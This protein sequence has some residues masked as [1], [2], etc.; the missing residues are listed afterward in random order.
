[1][2]SNENNSG[3][4]KTNIREILARRKADGLMEE[5]PLVVVLKIG[6]AIKNRGLTQ[7]DLAEMT[8]IRP[9]AISQMCRGFVDRLTLDHLQRIA[10]ALKI[11]DIRELI[12]LELLGEAWEDDHKNR[13]NN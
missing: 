12:D 11:T 2:V 10:S 5:D 6:D 1:M 8:G 4:S 13:S 9:A 7:K 3:K